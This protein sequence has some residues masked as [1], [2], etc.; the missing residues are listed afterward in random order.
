[1]GHEHLV[2]LI[3]GMNALYG[4]SEKHTAI[5]PIKYRGK[6]LNPITS[7]SNFDQLTQLLK[8]ILNLSMCSFGSLDAIPE[9]IN[10]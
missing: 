3:P 8:T 1:M 2:Q 10:R 4:S 9:K 7:M 5:S 6:I